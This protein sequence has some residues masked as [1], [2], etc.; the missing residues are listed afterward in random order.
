[1]TS[2]FS[3]SQSCPGVCQPEEVGHRNKNPSSEC[4]SVCKT[5]NA[6]VKA[7]GGFQ[8]VAKGKPRVSKIIA[9]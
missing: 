6:V 5:N 8:S 7:C 3:N 4:D 9:S 1:M 2:L